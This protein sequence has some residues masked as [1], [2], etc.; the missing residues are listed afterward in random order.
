MI[1]AKK[2]YQDGKE[3]IYTTEG[4]FISAK[5]KNKWMV[6]GQQSISFSNMTDKQKQRLF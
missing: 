6:G 1:L 4:I 5:L 3:I 2:Q